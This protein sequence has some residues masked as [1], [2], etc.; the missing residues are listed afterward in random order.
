MFAFVLGA[1]TTAGLAVLAASPRKGD[2]LYP[3]VEL[4]AKVLADVENNYVEDVDETRLIYG[5]IHGMLATLDPHTSFMDP[6]EYRAL[7]GDTAGEFGGLGFEFAQKDGALIVIGPIDDTPAARAGIRAGD[8]ITA[9]DNVSTRIMSIADATA[10]LRGAAGTPV[11]LSLLRPD[12]TQP[13][14]I[15]LVRE[16]VRVVSVEGRLIDGL[17]G[18]IKIRSFQD[19][20]AIELKKK[21]DEL[22]AQAGGAFEGLVL[23]LRNNPGGLLDEGIKVAD[24]F[25][26]RGTI[27]VTKGRDGRH[28]DEERATEKDTEPDYPLVVLI[29]R[30]TASASEVVSGALQDNKRAFIFGTTSFG[31]GSVQTVID[32]DDGSALKL[33]IA[34]YYTPSGRSIQ[35]RGITPDVLVRE[36]DDQARDVTDERMLPNHFRNTAPQDASLPP[37]PVERVLPFKVEGGEVITDQTLQAAVKAIHGW[38]YFT[39]ALGTE[40]AE[41][42]LRGPNR[43]ASAGGSS[44]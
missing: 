40:R 31:K 13:R 27:V 16:R 33:T 38:K 23:D 29:N 22:R 18:Y 35:E 41:A 44:H 21:L 26:S 10:R 32:L 17:V 30:G 15:S 5:A 14:T 36:S 4:F 25:L 34:R 6:S 28:P 39:Q 7:K 9:I 24:R 3:K 37:V 12:F 1:A 19:R 8:V 42:A 43:T 11:S 2:A 20:T